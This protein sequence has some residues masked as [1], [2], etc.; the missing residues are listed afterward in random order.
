MIGWLATVGM[1]W[2]QTLVPGVLWE[3]A[4]LFT[5]P[6]LMFF[7]A[8]V[9]PADPWSF[10]HG[11]ADDLVEPSGDEESE[12]GAEVAVV[13]GVAAVVHQVH[14]DELVGV[15]AGDGVAGEAHLELVALGREPAARSRRRGTIL[16]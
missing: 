7:S 1:N 14:G 11:Q 15:V 12:V 3:R 6:W 10:K 16:S 9:T 2:L 8:P 13:L 5:K 4:T